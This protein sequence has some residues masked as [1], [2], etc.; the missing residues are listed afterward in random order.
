MA[1]VRDANAHGRT[2]PAFWHTLS[3]RDTNKR[4]PHRPPLAAHSAQV[5]I[6]KERDLARHIRAQ[7][8]PANH[9][10]RVLFASDDNGYAS[11]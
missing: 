1:L 7:M 6:W 4:A 9:G 3:A 2:P 10:G 11:R 8:R 5:L